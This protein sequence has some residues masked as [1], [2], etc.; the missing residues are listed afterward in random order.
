MSMQPRVELASQTNLEAPTTTASPTME[1]ESS[2]SSSDKEDKHKKGVPTLFL[3]LQI[4]YAGI[5]AVL[6][7]IYFEKG[8][9][10]WESYSNLQGLL[11]NSSITTTLISCFMAV[12]NT[13]E[14]TSE[15]REESGAVGAALCMLIFAPLF[16]T[17]ILPGVVL[18]G[19]VGLVLLLL[20]FCVGNLYRMCVEYLLGV[21]ES[22]PY[23]KFAVKLMMEFFF[24]IF[25]TFI[26]QTLTNYMSI[27]YTYQPG[28]ISPGM[29]IDVIVREWDLRSQTECFLS[30]QAEGSKLGFITLFSFL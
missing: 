27:L 4:L 1:G 6:I 29:Y 25:F 11:A 26:I 3:R 20:I 8:A 23:Q 5:T 28:H 19:W 21:G 22:T 18:F 16:F 13:D 15:E 9:T 24:R 12:G 17:H 14:E 2:F 7:L 10:P 30:S